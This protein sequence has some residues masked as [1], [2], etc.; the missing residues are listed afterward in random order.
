MRPPFCDSEGL[1]PQGRCPIRDFRP[2]IQSAILPSGD[3]S[4]VARGNIN[5]ILKAIPKRSGIESVDRYTPKAFR[6]G[7]PWISWR[8]APLSLKS[9]AHLD[10]IPKPSA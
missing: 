6:R 5:R 9:C 4:D 1:A 2:L 10:G 7:I 8:R 3:F